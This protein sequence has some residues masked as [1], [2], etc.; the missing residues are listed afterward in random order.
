MNLKFKTVNIIKNIFALGSPLYGAFVAFFVIFAAVYEI[1]F[2][3]VIGITVEGKGLSIPF[4]NIFIE[5]EGLIALLIITFVIRSTLTLYSN[6]ILYGYSI[7]YIAHLSSALGFNI[8]NIPVKDYISH[9]STHTIYTETNQVIG[10]ILHPILLISRDVIFV[11][12]ISAFIIYQY[13]LIASIFFLYLTI[14][15][16]I[17]VLVLLPL[18]KSLGKKRQTLDQIRLKRTEDITQLRHEFFL[19][20]KN[21]NFVNDEFEKTNNTFS[22]VVARYMFVRSSNRTFLE[23]ILFISLI[24]TTLSVNT[25]PAFMTEFYAILFVAALRTLPAITSIVSFINGFSF[26]IP[27]LEKVGDLLS[28]KNTLNLKELKFGNKIEKIDSLEIIFLSPVSNK[29]FNHKFKFGEL[30]IIKGESGSGKSTLIKSLTGESDLFKTNIKIN[31]IKSSQSDFQKLVAYCPQD[32]HV[33]NASLMDNALIFCN[34][35]DG[36][37]DGARN[38]MKELDFGK[39]LMERDLINPSTISGGQ[40]RRLGLLRCLM[41][42]RKI[43]ICDEPTSELDDATSEIIKNLLNELSK[44]Q[45]VIVTSHDERLINSSTNILSL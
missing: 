9:D 40:K 30:N 42:D 27:A 15:S 3:Y 5:M 17:L 29:D 44:H 12:A 4:I 24:A 7:G 37:F 1:F 6:Y 43:L 21:K 36:L 45:L 33:I 2:L 41:L 10:N 19:T 26:H 38:K 31:G 20:V 11:L 39:S 32:I 13:K 25:D 28:K 14:G 23:I 8:T 22:D 34:N 16:I 18:L 35:K